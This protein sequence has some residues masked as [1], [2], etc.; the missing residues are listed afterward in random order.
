MIAYLRVFHRS[1]SVMARTGVWMYD[2]T[3]KLTNI[4]SAAVLDAGSYLVNTG[5]P[6]RLRLSFNGTDSVLEFE[7]EHTE[8]TATYTLPGV[9]VTTSK[10]VGIRFGTGHYGGV[11][12][13]SV[14]EEPAA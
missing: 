9:D 8:E 13:L 7:N 5:D 6:V 10:R 14:S 3:G 4:D 2:A 12:Q 1:G 11:T